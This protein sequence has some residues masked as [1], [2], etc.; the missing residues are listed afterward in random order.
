MY[1]RPFRPERRFS[2][3][4]AFRFLFVG[5]LL[6]METNRGRNR[7]VYDGFGEWRGTNPCTAPKYSWTESRSGMGVS[8][9]N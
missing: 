2:P 8:R 1:K 3:S 4:A 6:H 9:A 7:H 5:Q